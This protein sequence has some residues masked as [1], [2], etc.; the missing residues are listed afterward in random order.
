VAFGGD[1]DALK[2]LTGPGRLTGVA[3]EAVRLVGSGGLSA[4][5]GSVPLSDFAQEALRGHLEDLRWLEA[6]V[7]AHHKVIDAAAGVA[8]VLPLRFAVLYHDDSRVRSLLE[9]QREAWVSA[10][11]HVAGHTEWGVKAYVDPQAFLSALTD[12][13]TGE[14]ARPGTAYLLRRRAQ[15]EERETAHLRAR[16]LAQEIHDALAELAAQTVEHAPQDA[17]LAEYEGWMVLNDSYLVADTRTAEF[18]AAVSSLQQRF[19]D[20]RLERSGP[21]PPYSFTGEADPAEGRGHP[22]EERA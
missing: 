9:E 20:V 8:R 5:V 11:E 2:D 15:R 17:R 21:W 12:S 7:R 22:G 13:G 3:D 19:P 1:A 14:S 4:V 6:A 18:T 10:L 16:E